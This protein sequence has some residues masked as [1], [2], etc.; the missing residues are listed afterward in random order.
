MPLGSV[1]VALASIVMAVLVWA[2]TD[3]FGKDSFCRGALGS[4]EVNSVL[5]G[6]GRLSDTVAED[7]DPYGFPCEV[8]RTQ[9]IGNAPR[10]VLSTELV[11]QPADFALTSRNVWGNHASYSYF[12]G[13]RAGAVS[14]ERGW[15]L[16]PQK[17]LGTVPDSVRGDPLWHVQVDVENARSGK[18][19]LAAVL[20]RIA[21]HVTKQ[22]GCDTTER[23]RSV[24]SELTGP[25]DE[26]VRP[27]FEDLCGTR[28]FK[29]PDAVEGVRLATP[30]K[31][32]YTASGSTTGACELSFPG[33]GDRRLTFTRSAD[34]TLVHGASLSGVGRDAFKATDRLLVPCGKQ[35]VY[36][37]VHSS[38]AYGAV[39]EEQTS[40]QKEAAV[41][42]AWLRSYAKAVSS[43]HRCGPSGS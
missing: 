40:P 14:H 13:E 16:L 17:C 41:M 19:E 9:R 15:L 24:P 5:S 21:E 43:A 31:E 36:A 3:A 18:S 4:K 33:K 26:E 37:H 10:T 30:T 12:V 2:N 34:P 28:G 39:L 1:A 11:L 8:E 7:E 23:W 27:T 22:L 32:R 29:P 42:H 38:D 6:P 20:L 35:E 25:A